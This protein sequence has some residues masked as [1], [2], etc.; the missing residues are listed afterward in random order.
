[1]TKSVASNCVNETNQMLTNKLSSTA[2]VC[3]S[4][5]KVKSYATNQVDS[6]QLGIKK[7]KP[8]EADETKPKTPNNSIGTFFLLNSANI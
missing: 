3:N 8:E 1:M 6:K 7:S 2:I 5:F 4:C